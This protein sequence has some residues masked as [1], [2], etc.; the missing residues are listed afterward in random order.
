MPLYIIGPAPNPQ[1]YQPLQPLFGEADGFD[2]EG[3]DL[4]GLNREGYDRDGNPKNVN[5]DELSLP[6]LWD[7][8][9]GYDRD[10]FTEYVR[11]ITRDLVTPRIRFCDACAEPDWDRN[12]FTARGNGDT[13]VCESCRDTWITCDCCGDIYPAGELCDTLEG[14]D[15]CDSCRDSSFYYCEHCEGYYDSENSED[16]DHGNDYSGCC[17]SPQQAF[18]IRNDGEEPLGNDERVTVTLPAG[19]IS[20]E[21]LM[22][23]RNYLFREAQ[24]MQP[25]S[26][27]LDS[28]GDQWQTRE[29]NF[30]K[31]LS[32]RAYKVYRLKLTPGVMSHVGCIASD[33]SKPVS[34]EVEVTRDLNMGPAEF[35]HEDSCWWGSYGESRCALKTN[36][37][38]GLRTFNGYGA[39]SGR[40]WV[41]PLK[42]D[43]GA[44]LPT[45][46]TEN[47]AAFV[48][49]NGYGALNGYAAPRI[50]AHMAG[51]TYRKISFCCDPMYV[52][53]GGYLVAPEEIASRY[54][55]GSLSLSVSQHSTLFHVE[56]AEKAEREAA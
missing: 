22:S 53:A 19:V 42:K 2:G 54:T 7:D 52:N 43:D 3:Y 14:H 39:V 34:V 38:F 10:A 11:E 27:D 31:R 29:G 26:Y 32:R 24:D 9:N 45:F 15:V 1:D 6:E 35:Y 46:N 28:L 50:M 21:G 47:P 51:W 55:D 8:F 4:N 20:A 30:A 17:D 41:M 48:V 13:R 33:H 49:F 56:A 44:L 25:L 36:G 23:I 40:A 12:M 5:A 37:G 18:T 16:H